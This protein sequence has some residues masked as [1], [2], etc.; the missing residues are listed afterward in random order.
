M[1]PPLHFLPFPQ[2]SESMQLHFTSHIHSALL[3]EWPFRQAGR[4]YRPSH[5][6]TLGEPASSF[7]HS[8]LRAV[9]LRPIPPVIYRRNVMLFKVVCPVCRGISGSAAFSVNRCRW[10]RARGAKPTMRRE[11]SLWICLTVWRDPEHVPKPVSPSKAVCRRKCPSAQMVH[12]YFYRLW[13][14]RCEA[15]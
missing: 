7:Q 15:L 3:L 6:Q 9:A 10:T 2:S 11:I 4:Q 12:A 13:S 14:H 8:S 1:T 5:R